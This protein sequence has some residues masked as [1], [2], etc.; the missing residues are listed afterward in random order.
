MLYIIKEECGAWISDRWNGL[1]DRFDRADKKIF[2]SA[3]DHHSHSRLREFFYPD[4]RGR[5]LAV[6]D[7]IA[8]SFIFISIILLLLEFIADE[9]T[10]KLFNYIFGFILV[11]FIIE[12]LCRLYLAGKIYAKSIVGSIDLFCISVDMLSIAYLAF[13]F[14]VKYYLVDLPHDPGHAAACAKVLRLLRFL[15]FFRLLRLLQYRHTMRRVRTYL[16][17]F[18]SA[19]GKTIMVIVL[20]VGSPFFILYIVNPDN[21]FNDVLSTLFNLSQQ[22]RKDSE[23]ASEPIGAVVAL[24]LVFTGLT[25]LTLFTSIFNP[26]FARVLSRHSL[27]VETELKRNHIVVVANDDLGV[28][29]ELIYVLSTY[30]S[31]KVVFVSTSSPMQEKIGSNSSISVFSGQI[32]DRHICE[33]ANIDEAAVL[34]LIGDVDFDHHRFEFRVMG[35]HAFH[36]RKLRILW[37]KSFGED[38]TITTEDGDRSKLTKINHRHLAETLK[39]NLWRRDSLQF[40][41]YRDLLRYYDR[42]FEPVDDRTAPATTGHSV[43]L[44]EL[45]DALRA[46]C[47]E[48]NLYDVQII[49]QPVQNS[50]VVSLGSSSADA[51]H[52]DE[53][54]LLFAIKEVIK[55]DELEGRLCCA[56][57]DFRLL[58]FG[59]TFKKDE[60][61]VDV[62][63]FG[64]EF[65]TALAIFHDITMPGVLHYWLSDPDQLSFYDYQPPRRYVSKT[66]LHG[67]FDTDDCI[68]LCIKSSV[69]KLRDV[70][71]FPSP[72]D[73]VRVPDGGQILAIAG[74]NA[75][76][77]NDVFAVTADAPS[78][79]A[80]PWRAHSPFSPAETLPVPPAAPS[81]PEP[82]PVR[83]PPVA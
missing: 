21:T 5:M 81:A 47:A 3:I 24:G 60:I 70:V 65:A 42:W 27:D 33:Q 76:N 54:L 20:L 77:D 29:D 53:G 48:E 67:Q 2:Q 14:Y 22:I 35:A 23:T 15:R 37:L 38:L 34:V 63:L 7:K 11:A 62:F 6:A 46:A 9:R 31:R 66:M 51:D 55:K 25:L 30:S 36:H 28:V 45:E 1:L 8:L 26:I 72:S 12:Y 79:T 75:F 19:A 41:L 49:R 13:E 50:L 52:R 71:I 68:G 61:K 56:V 80:S 69:E 74:V 83:K 16:R 78:P 59:R 58:E 18:F 4:G 73:K 39:E 43:D 44:P 64:V 17:P 40:A 57:R 82:R 10:W 32:G